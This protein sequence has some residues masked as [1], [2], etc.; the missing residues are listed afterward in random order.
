MSEA[1]SRQ[2]AELESRDVVIRTSS[3]RCPTPQY[4]DWGRFLILTLIAWAHETALHQIEEKGGT[5]LVRMLLTATALALISLD[6]Y[7]LVRE[8]ARLAG[9]LN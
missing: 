9:L 1:L 3:C 4:R 7:C 5:K 6:C 2:V 8:A